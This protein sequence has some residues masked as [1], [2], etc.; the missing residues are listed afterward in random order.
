MIVSLVNDVC[1]CI[2]EIDRLD[3][4]KNDMLATKSS[5]EILQTIIKDINCLVAYTAVIGWKL[6]TVVQESIRQECEYILSNI[7]DSRNNFDQ[8]FRQTDVLSS[9]ENS[10][11]ETIK[12]V[13]SQWQN[14]ANEWAREPL[15]LL[16]LVKYLSEVK[17]HA[18]IYDALKE[19]I[20]YFINKVPGSLEQLTIFEQN[21]QKLT[22]LLNA[23][24]LDVDVREFLQ[25]VIDGQ[26]TMKD[27]TT[28]IR[29]WCQSGDREHDFLITI[30]R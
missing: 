18:D 9:A 16:N 6:P 21:V 5:Y 11:Q 27:I 24:E 20:Q 30:A 25:K 17:D 28:E 15:Q 4:I 14:Y 1:A 22:E 3:K 2:S 23:I 29:T 19:R 10:L 13:E 12:K 7:I 26:A 8:D